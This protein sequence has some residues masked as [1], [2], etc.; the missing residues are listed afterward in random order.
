MPSYMCGLAWGQPDMI[1]KIDSCRH[2]DFSSTNTHGKPIASKPTL[3]T[4]TLIILPCIQAPAR[5][6]VTIFST[7]TAT[8]QINTLSL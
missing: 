2:H 7:S 3:P 8:A 5:P 6:V 1:A 4:Q